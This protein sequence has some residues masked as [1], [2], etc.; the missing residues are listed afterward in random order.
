[1]QTDRAGYR[2]VIGVTGSGTRKTIKVN[3]IVMS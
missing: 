1:M 2:V 3:I